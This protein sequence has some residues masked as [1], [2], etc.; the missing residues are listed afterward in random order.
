M[1]IIFHVLFHTDW[2]FSCCFPGSKER[3]HVTLL[4]LWSKHKML[5]ITD[6]RWTEIQRRLKIEHAITISH[7]VTHILFWSKYLSIQNLIFLYRS[8]QPQLT[9][10]SFISALEL[11]WSSFTSVDRITP[12]NG[13]ISNWGSCILATWLIQPHRHEWVQSSNVMG[14]RPSLIAWEHQSDLSDRLYSGLC[15]FSSPK[16]QYLQ[17]PISRPYPKQEESWLEERDSCKDLKKRSLANL[18]SCSWCQPSS[19]KPT[20]LFN[21]KWIEQDASVFEIFLCC[22][23]LWRTHLKASTPAVQKSEQ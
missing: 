8:K 5:T 2:S 1:L 4:L 3:M 12:V 21:E 10:R 15:A 6:F 23:F 9:H 22:L 7:V 18:S 16:Q 20:E 11:P 14:T 13:C 17:P 19:A